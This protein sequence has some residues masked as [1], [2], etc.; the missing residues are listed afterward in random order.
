[1]FWS[2]QKTGDKCKFDDL[3]G[4]RQKVIGLMGVSALRGRRRVAGWSS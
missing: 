4:D 1:L 3:Q 2:T